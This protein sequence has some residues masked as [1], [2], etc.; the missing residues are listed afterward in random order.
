MN[1]LSLVFLIFTSCLLAQTPKGAEENAALRYW[2]ALAQMSDQTITETQS[3]QLEAIAN[4]SAAWD[5]DAFGKL[6]TENRGAVETM[7]RGTAL[8]YCAWG[9]DYALAESAPI[10]Q[11]DRG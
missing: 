2:N 11:I 10:P 7:V 9:V 3:K 5:E 6:V 8:L 1:R 4:G